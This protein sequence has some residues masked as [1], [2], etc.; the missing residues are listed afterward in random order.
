MILASPALWGVLV[1]AGPALAGSDDGPVSDYESYVRPIVREYCLE[2]HSTEVGEGDIDLERFAGLD[3]LRADPRLWTK[4]ATVLE[5]GEMPPEESKALPDADR[6]KLRG[7]V[8]S[9]LKAEAAKHAGDP[10]PV[11]LRRLT[12]AQYTYTL[13]D[14]T[15][16]DS[17]DPAR[18]FPPDS[19]AG[20]GFTNTGAA[21]V[22]SP[23]LLDKYLDAAKGVAS[24]AVFLPDG[25][26]FS[27]GTSPRDW[28]D[29][30]VASIRR[31]Y[32]R[33]AAATAG[34]QVNLQGVVFATNEGGRLPLDRYLA[35]LLEERE[36][37][38]AGSRTIEAV[39]AERE[40]SPKYLGLV[41]QAIEKDTRPS[42]LLD[43]IRAAWK[44]AGP[45]D[46]KALAARFE[47]WQAALWKFNSVG[48]IG[49][50]G[51][52]TAWMEPVSPLVDQQEI[53]LPFPAGDQGE[54]V[55]Y[56]A[57]TDAGD[58]P[59]DDLAVWR[60]PRIVTPG[61]PDLPLRDVRDQYLRL[62]ARRGEV[63]AGAA[64]A[65][66]VATRIGDEPA[67]LGSLAEGSGVSPEV[68]GAWLRYLGLAGGPAEIPAASLLS[69]PLPRTGD[70]D[71]IRGFSAAGGDLPNVLANSSD[72]HVRVPGNMKP[73]G[74][75]MHPTPDLRVV[76]G[77]RS[78]VEAVVRV[79]GVAQH[80]HTECGNG[81]AWRLEL[82]RGSTRRRLGEGIAHGGVPVSFGPFAD[83]PVTP[84]DVIALSIGPRDGNHSCDL[85][86]VDLTIASQAEG[87]P[88][89]DLAADVAPD[90]LAGN[91][92]ADRLGHP[93][94]WQF[95]SE[96]ETNAS[97]DAVIPAGSLLARWQDSRDPAERRRLAREIQALALAP[98]P[99]DPKSPDAVLH[100]QLTSLRGPLLDG[101][102]AGTEPAAEN[103]AAPVGLD[104]SMFGRLA[105]GQPIEPT[106][107]ATSSPVEIRLPAELVAGSEFVATGTIAASG[108]GEG[109]AQFVAS[110]APVATTAGAI[111]GQ[112][113]VTSPEGAARA[114]I[115]G[116][117]ATFRRLFPPALCYAKIV[118]V[119]E[120]VTLTLYHREDEN[121]RRLMLEEGQAAELDR[122]WDELHFVS[123]D[124]LTL[125]DAF[126]QLLEYASQDADPSVFEPMRPKIEAR[127]AAFRQT[128]REAE[129]RQVAAVIDF[130]PLAFRRPLAAEE[131]DG[132][133]ALYARLRA[134][135]IPHDEAIRLTLAR[136][137]VSPDFLYR[138]EHAATGSES[139][140]VS[141]WELANRLSYFLWSSAPD[142]ALRAH[143]ADGSLADPTVLVA[144]LRRM[145]A[146]SRARRLADEFA[147]QWLQV[148]DFASLDEKSE[149][150]FPTFA[151]LRPAMQEETIRLFL[152]LF[153]A[154]RSVLSLLDADHTFLNEELAK[155]YGI[156]GVA[157]PE[158][159]RVDG[160]R[161]HGR[162]GILGLATTLAK[163]SGASRTSPILRG[164]W[165]S[166]VVLGEKLPRP[167]KDVPLL[168]E[169][170]AATD[171][172]TVRQLVE[173]HTSDPRCASCHV[174]ID[175]FGFALE[176]YDA[177]GRYRER[178]LADRP[179]DTKSTLPDG[180]A[181]DGLDGL[182]D[183]LLTDRRD[184]FV[185]QFCRKLLGYSLGRGV[186]LSDEPL[187]DE[188]AARLKASDHRVSA[189]L[190]TIVL[191]RQFRE[192]RGQSP[193]S[194][195]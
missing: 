183:Y 114:R 44:S 141:P 179:V 159:R 35:A 193:E 17:L 120:V 7:W 158:W 163:Q 55:L 111:P 68:L 165:I 134:E 63:L 142:E 112:P 41:W 150:H 57:A 58:G 13:R 89:W 177:I 78:P 9:F 54:V 33:F 123:R 127:A 140:P 155:H 174:R 21:L 31:F 173:K 88:A 109:S 20:E 64:A 49:K 4:V 72:Q 106:S 121:L 8:M 94:V 38:R 74:I 29:E 95:Y 45:A 73:H 152:D 125:V 178:D 47:P 75:A 167:P 36:A 32:D 116:D 143:A 108:E 42:L 102:A 67:D 26:R 115:E 186:L 151:H 117:L 62:S 182:R 149:S 139:A 39:A 130:A 80:A 37:L 107:L 160:V 2:C 153:Q 79:S 90:I 23:S 124:A 50:V 119:D 189:A 1:A 168:P 60:N 43:P 22:M 195:R 25:L 181:I 28:S 171:G 51:G 187:L 81:V 40:L 98:A 146:D 164:N 34:E 133:R 162:G 96:P 184:A 135:E 93:A 145:V 192:I 136:L 166:E 110:L 91:P 52:P 77:W 132:I 65:L 87:G 144:E 59:A 185:R 48:H 129:P 92:H 118:P 76:A 190:E 71:F 82:R 61:R 69:T 103:G 85:T 128:L 83:L 12:N 24:H 30:G 137:F 86:A 191:S 84:G 113:I 161:Q 6:Q 3:D 70:Y 175:P 99:G 5:T 19:A 188:M 97:A 101:L 147:L 27:A 11:V 122:L 66:E 170:E 14:L 56:L 169:D 104:P 100:R 148:Y 105:D 176:R 16:I 154:D 180:S 131:Q 157:G 138:V 194:S 18:E 15:G 46:A 10:G 53:R 156:D 126:Q 172:L